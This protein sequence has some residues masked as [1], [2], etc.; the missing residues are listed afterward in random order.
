MPL[1]A[2][3]LENRWNSWYTENY[4][5][6]GYDKYCSYFLFYLLFYLFQYC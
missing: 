4:I 6:T 1:V 5:N 2:F 3:K